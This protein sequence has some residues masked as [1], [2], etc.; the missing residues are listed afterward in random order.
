MKIFLLDNFDSFTFNLVD[1]F[2]Q[3]GCDVRVYRNDVNIDVVDEIAPDL[4]VLSPGPS[5]PK[6]AGNMMKLIDRYHLKYPIFGVCLGHEALIEYFGGSLKFVKPVHGKS[7]PIKHNKK[8]IFAGLDQNFLA[9]RYH[10]LCAKKTPK[11]FEITAKT[12]GLV[13]AVMHKTLPIESVQFH[14]ESVL[15]MKRGQGMKLIKNVVGKYAPKSSVEKFLQDTVDGKLP[16]NEQ[17][18]F[19]GNYTIEKIKPADLKA[20]ADF[21]TAKMITLD[22]PDAIDICGTGGS[23]L[24]RINTSTIAAFIL[25]E[26]G[27]GIAKHGNMAASGRF[28]S[29][30]LLEKLDIDINKS[31]EQL[32]N[33]Y[34]LNGLAF[35]FARNFHPVMKYFAEARKQVGKPTI[36][37]ILGP[38]LNP[39]KVK[40]QI[41]GTGFRDQMELIAEACKLMGKEHVIIVCGDDGLD[42]ITL[43]GKT[44]VVEL[45]NGKL[46]KYF[47]EPEDFGIKKCSFKKIAGGSADFNV[48]IAKEI[49]EGKCTSRHADLVY[50]NCAMALRL[51]GKVDNL[52]EG[53]LQAKNG[54]NILEE[55][56]A[57]KI[58]KKSDRNFSEAVSGKGIAVIAEIK[59]SSPSAGKIFEGDF[60]AAKIARIYEKSGA[61]AISVVTDEKYFE[62]SFDYMKQA[63]AATRHTPILCKDFIMEE[64]QIH[65]AREYGADAILLIV[66]ILDEGKIHNF[67]RVAANLGM[68]VVVEIHNENEL[69][70]AVKS[71]AKIIGINNRNLR[72]FSV[73]LNVTNRLAKKCPRNILIISESGINSREDVERLDKRVNAV[74]VGTSLMKAIDMNGKGF[75]RGKNLLTMTN[76]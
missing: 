44:K 8:G 74:L 12:D 46:K 67:I 31:P 39:A 11:C 33:D 72:D 29:F 75:L 14:P 4:I 26:L 6:N 61:G 37:N 34:K 50:V 20:F 45:H 52:K 24:A 64:W 18:K 76:T 55:I 22:M 3:L 68:D 27:V 21:M 41:I 42:E 10:S 38:L 62:G 73:D 49:I 66:G 13:M 63:R 9:G 1:Y 15:T 23:G 53:Y 47:L 58:L 19:L 59:K 17:I 69:K 57:S 40:K 2:A 65:K 30:D 60:D 54:K 43:T 48:R 5:I 35:I 25:A 36:F 16:L 28:G 70:T 51:A 32:E 71:G 56:A 7:S